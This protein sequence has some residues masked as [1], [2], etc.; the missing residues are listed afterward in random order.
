MLLPR[1]KFLESSLLFGA[2]AALVFGSARFGFAQNLFGNSQLPAEVLRDPM[3][4]FS[5]E[6]FEPYVGG[7]FEAPDARGKM[8]AMKLLKVDLI[9]RVYSHRS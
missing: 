9:N 6:T 7:Y 2:S 4:R 3:Y 5:R 8:V 1:R